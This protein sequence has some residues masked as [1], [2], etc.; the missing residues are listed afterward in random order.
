MVAKP[1]AKDAMASD[2]ALTP[3]YS[4][5]EHTLRWCC[6]QCGALDFFRISPE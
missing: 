5:V 2:R 3:F 1:V 4:R 6:T